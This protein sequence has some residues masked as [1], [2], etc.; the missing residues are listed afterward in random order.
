M[1]RDA[2]PPGRDRILGSTGEPF[3]KDKGDGLGL[4]L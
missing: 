1:E 4:D 2:Y 3:G